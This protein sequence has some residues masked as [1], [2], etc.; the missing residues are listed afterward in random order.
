MH[1]FQISQK[2]KIVFALSVLVSVFWYIGQTVDVYRFSFVGVFFEILW[3]PMVVMFFLLPV[4]SIYFLCKERFSIKS[5]YL[6][7]ILIIGLAFFASTYK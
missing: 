7:S 2:S 5:L 4:I 3:L 6:Y 1:A